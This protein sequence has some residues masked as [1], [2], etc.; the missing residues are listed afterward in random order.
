[1]SYNPFGNIALG[2]VQSVVLGGVGLALVPVA[3]RRRSM[4]D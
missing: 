2:N 3:A 4:E 1:M